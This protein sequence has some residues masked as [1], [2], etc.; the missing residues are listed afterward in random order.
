MATAE[1]TIKRR[2]GTG[3]EIAKRLRRAGAVPA[4]LYGGTKTETVSLD[5]KAVLR[6]IHG[7][8][9]TT[10]LL[11]LKFE[12]ETGNGA[13]LAIIRE[14]QFDPVSDAL[15][16]VDLQ[17]VSA[18]RAITVRVAVRPVGEA[19]GV[20]DQ[21]GILNLVL[22]ELE[23][24]CLP[25]AIPQR[26]DADVSALMI[27]N[28]LTVRELV[29]PAGVRILNDPGQAVATVAPPMA[30]EAPVV[31]A[32]ATTAVAEPEVLTERKPKE[33]EEAPAADDKRP[34]RPERAEKTEK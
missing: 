30:E 3:K 18:D 4:I 8:E 33:G 28:V 12:G 26:I 27:G 25:T 9:G 2:E 13:R 31:A 24:S 29:A 14:L 10:Q 20:R 16:H 5:P 15:L 19:A 23:V 11:T 7:H 21:K 22:H 32:T 34:K 1:L 6:M 17:E